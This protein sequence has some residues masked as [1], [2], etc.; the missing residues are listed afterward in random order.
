MNKNR[1][2]SDYMLCSRVSSHGKV[3]SLE[4]PFKLRYEQ[5]FSIFLK[6]K[7]A[8]ATAF[9]GEVMNVRLYKDETSSPCPVTVGCW[10]EL[11]VVEISADNA[12]LLDKYD[13]YWGS[14]S[15]GELE[16]TETV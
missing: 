15:V 2:V 4:K 13:I 14:G 10:Q 3:E 7:D 8:T 9:F 12:P 6:P 11:Q 16:E 1:F 5:P